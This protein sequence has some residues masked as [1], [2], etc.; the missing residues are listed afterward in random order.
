MLKREEGVCG[1]NSS[2]GLEM[3]VV[4]FVHVYRAIYKC[5]RVSRGPNYIMSLNELGRSICRL[6]C[7]TCSVT[8]EKKIGEDY[9]TKVGPVVV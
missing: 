5:E 7:V 1:L 8:W 4:F 6:L 3:V 9:V 2:L